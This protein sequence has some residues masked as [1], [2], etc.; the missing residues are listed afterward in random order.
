MYA[1]LL[2]LVK[3]EKQSMDDVA[4]VAYSEAANAL[5]AAPSVTGK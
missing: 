3:C 4:V 5:L 1:S 2:I